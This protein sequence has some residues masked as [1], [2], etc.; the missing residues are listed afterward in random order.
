MEFDQLFNDPKLSFSE[1]MSD[2]RTL[3]HGHYSDL[4]E[5]FPLGPIEWTKRD[6]TVK[7]FQISLSHM[8]KQNTNIQSI[9]EGHD[10]KILQDIITQ[11]NSI[12]KCDKKTLKIIWLNEKIHAN[13]KS[14]IDLTKTLLVEIDSMKIVSV[15]LNEKKL[16]MPL[17]SILHEIFFWYRN[18]AI[19]KIQFVDELTT[20]NLYLRLFVNDFET[21]QFK[22]I[23]ASMNFFK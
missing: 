22:V 21:Q 9:F 18:E 17:W 19:E 7:N 8:L 10:T 3:S 5:I 1:L 23:N 4:N 13:T 14:T 20:K 11:M 12:T 2:G 15:E 16:V 6:A